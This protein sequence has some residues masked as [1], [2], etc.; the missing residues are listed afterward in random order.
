MPIEVLPDN[1][2][3]PLTDLVRQSETL[4]ISWKSFALTLKSQFCPSIEIFNRK[5]GIIR[6][7]IICALSPEDQDIY[8]KDIPRKKKLVDDVFSE[9]RALK[10]KV[11]TKINYYLSKL[12]LMMFEEEMALKKRKLN[13]VDEESSDDEDDGDSA[14]HNDYCDDR[15]SDGANE[16]SSD[17]SGTNSMCNKFDNCAL[18]EKKV[19]HPLSRGCHDE[20]ETPLEV[21]KMVD[22]FINKDVL[23]WDPFYSNGQSGEHMKSLGW[24]VRHEDDDFFNCDYGDII[25][26]NPPFSILENVFNR[27]RTLNKP[28]ILT[29]PP[30]KIFNVYFRRIFE[31]VMSSIQLI[32]P[33]GRSKFIRLESDGT[34][35]IQE[36]DVL[37]LCYRM[38]IAKD[39]TLI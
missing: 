8:G 25:V 6:A 31:D 39:L 11:Q 18:D 34:E 13:E 16:I 26:S 5:S 2:A 24:N 23:V 38:N 37:F 19:R 9:E 10:L 14:G 35:K 17:S 20:F 1:L 29:I 4:D 15:V 21:W 30:S 22:E 3:S 12:K 28:F 27:L 32:I 36:F 7:S 33:I